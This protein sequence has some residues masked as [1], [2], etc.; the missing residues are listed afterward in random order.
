[1]IEFEFYQEYAPGLIENPPALVTFQAPLA[2]ET[3][4]L[5]IDAIGLITQ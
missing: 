4:M 3:Y 2:H 5:E 1:M